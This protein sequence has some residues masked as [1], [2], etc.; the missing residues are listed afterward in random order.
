MILIFQL[1]LCNDVENDLSINDWKMEETLGHWYNHKL[2]VRNL[3]SIN[4]SSS[5]VN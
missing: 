5:L 3:R 2:F 1:T 4:E